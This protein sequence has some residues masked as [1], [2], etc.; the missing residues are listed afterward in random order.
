MPR[1]WREREE[2][3]EEEE[4]AL[5]AGDLAGSLTGKPAHFGLRLK[6]RQALVESLAPCYDGLDRTFC[7]R[8]HTEWHVTC[9]VS[10][11]R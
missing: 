4:E 11:G 6:G 5:G 10:R 7:A 2:D 3:E 1:H 9:V 8:P